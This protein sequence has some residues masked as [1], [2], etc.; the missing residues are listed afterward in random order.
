MKNIPTVIVTVN[1]VIYIDNGAI[2]TSLIGFEL[3]EDVILKKMKLMNHC[4][5]TS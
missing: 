5:T 4:K 1:S 2:K 3:T